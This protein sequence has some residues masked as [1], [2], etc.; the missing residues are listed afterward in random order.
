MS[1]SDLLFLLLKGTALLAIFIVTLIYINRK[2]HHH[3]KTAQ[4]TNTATLLIPAAPRINLRF[5][6]ARNLRFQWRD[7]D[8]ASHY[9]LLERTDDQA[10]FSSAGSYIL[11]GRESLVWTVP[12]YSRLNAQ[13]KLRAF[14]EQG[15]TDSAVVSVSTELEEQLRYL[16][17]SDINAAEFFGFAIHLSKGGN[18]LVI[19]EDDFSSAYPRKH[20][21]TPSSYM[22][23]AV[24]FN[25]ID[26]GRWEQTAYINALAKA[27][28]DEDDSDNSTH[29]RPP[30]SA[31]E[32]TTEQTKRS[33]SD[34]V[35]EI[36]FRQLGGVLCNQS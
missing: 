36:F 31:K 11:P 9:Q 14:N 3:L 5:S 1:Y 34:A 30:N 19:A 32:T 21:T 15:F 13:Y 2:Q 24:V 10:D 18:T 23:S 27:E 22:G 20:G 6:S 12:L 8:G 35:P 17:T 33:R 4:Q 28:I 7:V 16:Q 25:R 26:S 29:S